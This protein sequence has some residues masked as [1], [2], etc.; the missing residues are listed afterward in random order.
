ML[1]KISDMCDVISVMYDKSMLLRRLKYDTPKDKQDKQQIDM[2]V[3][4]I[5]AL[6]LQ[7]AHDRSPYEK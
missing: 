2:L 1:H 5:Q 4:D 3:V 6:A 7:I